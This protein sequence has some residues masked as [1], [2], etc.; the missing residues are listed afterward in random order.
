MKRFLKAFLIIVALLVTVG[1]GTYQW[2]NMRTFQVF[3]KL[4]HR[5]DTEEKVVAL[6]FDDGPTEQTNDILAILESEQ[7]PATF[8]VVG[9]SLATHPDLGKAIANQGH[10]LGNHSYTHQ[11]MVVNK[12]PNFIKSELQQTDD[13]IRKTGYDGPIQFRPPFGKKLV[14]LPWYVSKAGKTT[15]M[16]DIEVDSTQTPE[17]ITNFVVANTQSGS[18]ILLHPMYNRSDLEA[19]PTIITELKQQG[20][21]FV[22]VSELFEYQKNE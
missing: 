12:T 10:E 16:W 8:F 9:E 11:R 3:G 13:E 2:M 5:V 21:S 15:V 4:V 22:R 17:A 19:L 1:Y 6:T 14:L 20:Y 7:V 18:I